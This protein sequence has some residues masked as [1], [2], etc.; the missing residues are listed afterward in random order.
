MLFGPTF[1]AR[2]EYPYTAAVSTVSVGR[3][4]TRMDYF[5]YFIY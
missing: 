4:F 2:I 3:L 5:S 1:A